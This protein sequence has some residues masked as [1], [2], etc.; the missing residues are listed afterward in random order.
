VVPLGAT[1][2]E[3]AFQALDRFLARNAPGGRADVILLSDG[4]ATL[5]ETAAEKLVAKVVPLL[6]GRRA[7]F[8][9]VAMGARHDHSVLRELARRTGG[10]FRVI[11]P[12][13]NVA[14][15]AL[16]L[17]M[18]LGSQL[19]PAPTVSF[20]GVEVA[21]LYPEQ[22]DTLVASEE[23]IVLG[24]YR[25]AGKLTVAIQ[26]QGKPHITATFDL[27][28]TDSRNVFVPRLW[29]R[30]RLEDLM[31]RPQTDD[32]VKEIVDLSQEFTLI[33]PYTSFLVLESEKE[34]PKYGVVRRKRRRYWEEM[35]KL[36]TAPPT[37]ELR[38]EPPRPTT[39]GPRRA[40]EKPEPEATTKLKPFTLADLDLSLLRPQR[41]EGRVLATALATLSLEVYYR[42]L[43][44]Y[45]TAPRPA[46]APPRRIGRA[47]V[48]APLAAEPPAPS[49]RVPAVPLST[50]ALDDL[51]MPIEDIPIAPAPPSRE[52][53]GPDLEPAQDLV[54]EVERPIESVELPSP[55]PIF[56]VDAPLRGATRG[57]YSGRSRAGRSR[58]IGGRGGTTR[59]AESA[60]MAGLIW[61]AKNQ[62]RDGCWRG[63]GC[64]E[65]SLA[66]LAFLGAGYTHAKG[67][68]KTTVARGLGWLK[69]Q[70][71]RQGG[72]GRDAYEQ[73]LAA[74]AFSE[75]YGLTRSPIV[76]WQAQWAIDRLLKLQEQRDGKP[77]GLGDPLTSIWATLAVKSA[78]CSELRVPQSAVE[79]SRAY[80][81]AVTSTDGAVGAE[82]KPAPGEFHPLHT[83]GC[84]LARQ[85]IGG[86]DDDIIR[87]AVDLIH[88]RVDPNKAAPDSMYL[89]Y[90][91][92]AAMFQMGG[93]YWRDWNQRFRDP[94][95]KRQVHQRLDAK[96]N[97]IRGSW[98]PEGIW[99]RGRS[100]L[101]LD[102]AQ[103]DAAARE[104]RD[105]LAEF[106]PKPRT[107]WAYRRLATTLSRLQDIELLRKMLEGTR[108]AEARA[109]LSCRLG[110]AH[111]RQRRYDDAL[112]AFRSAYALGGRPDNILAAYVGALREAGKPRDALELLL[113]DAR[114]G[115]MSPAR[116]LLIAE[117]T[118]DPATDV[119]DPVGF[120]N[121]GLGRKRAR[122][123][124]LKALMAQF[125]GERNLAQARARLLSQA[126][127]ESGRGRQ[128]LL[129]HV[130]ALAAVG[131]NEQAFDL[132][133]RE[134][135]RGRVG[136]ESV[137]DLASL[138]VAVKTDVKAL[139]PRLDK[140]LASRPEIRRAVCLRA[141][142]LAA[143]KGRTELAAALLGKAA[144]EGILPVNYVSTCI[145]SLL[146][147]NQHERAAALLERFIQGGYHTAWAF[148]SLA[149]AYAKLGRGKRDLLRAVSAEVEILPRDV[150]PRLKLA[151]HYE[152]A[153]RADAAL[154][155][156]CEAVRIRPE[157][158]LLYR[159]AV[160]RAL[161]AGRFDI[162]SE[163]LQDMRKRFGQRPD[164]L[165]GL[166]PQ[167]PDLLQRLG[168]AGEGPEAEGIRRQIRRLLA[169]PR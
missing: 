73:A 53:P 20:S 115:M 70:R 23:L 80:L 21:A 105:R 4:I 125:A 22:P 102:Q 139:V 3:A 120:V 66:L 62:D 140:G 95:V 98:E 29:A 119:A 10:L 107:A 55:T 149:Q 168:R 128:Y 43:P 103:Q 9:G 16:R 148:Q 166:D 138:A 167:L 7:R 127:T 69:A 46:Q 47:P 162:A 144:D 52:D 57:I 24:R 116:R 41:A 150:Q 48:P 58:V 97:F 17:A 34:Y 114:R 64:E 101:P 146:A 164:L 75:A 137:D 134:A 8:H 15:E 142:S 82:G 61:L 60:V 11:M 112:S 2:L 77:F 30:E 42:F 63:G 141:G 26:Q 155:Q 163:M 40:A 50:T 33:T 136:P 56:A 25:K 88:R 19:L 87:A 143:G 18:A 74:L 147:A 68:F 51:A 67:R 156:Y 126:Y 90:F 5:G 124:E 78:L 153:G 100:P 59:H 71:D 151:E 133:L 130:R 169:K 36:R 1:S 37:E 131:Q 154:T 122:D 54:R 32:V 109:I 94:L 31:L 6:K 38:A 45:K 129:P 108:D 83:A 104:V 123:P 132:L 13:E 44:V 157:D 110:L 28:E 86:G 111:L 161:A 160:E 79:G 145:R 121:E 85:F 113:A 152:K 65:T 165:R 159:Q 76:G 84:L 91:A 118:F 158:P 39:T 96:G 14:A 117:L 27:P 12:G 81:D 106:L 89:R 49:P 35:G 72:I 92:T 99:I 135:A 93:E